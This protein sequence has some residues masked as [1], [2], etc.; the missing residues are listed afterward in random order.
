VESNRPSALDSLAK[1]LK[2]AVRFRPKRY[3]VAA[4]ANAAARLLANLEP[5]WISFL[6]PSV[7]VSVSGERIGRQVKSLASRIADRDELPSLLGRFPPVVADG[8]SEFGGVDEQLAA[9]L[10]RRIVDGSAT[11]RRNLEDLLTGSPPEWLVTADPLAWIALAEAASAYSLL[12]LS[13]QA[14]ERAVT[15]GA[16]NPSRWLGR[17]SLAWAQTGDR[18][19]ARRVCDAAL[20]GSARDQFAVV[21]D[22]ILREDPAAVLQAVEASNPGHAEHVAL[23]GQAAIALHNLG[24]PDA[25]IERLRA[26]LSGKP[27]LT[28]LAILLAR[29]LVGR[30]TRT[31]GEDRERDL[32]EALKLATEA[33]DRRRAWGMA[34]E[35]AIPILCDIAV[36][37]GDRAAVL[38]YGLAE[39]DGEATAAEAAAT[40]VAEQTALRFIERG[41]MG[42]ARALFS[43]LP[44]GY[45]RL[46][47]EGAL[48]RDDATN[49]DRAV[50]VL[51]QA[52]EAA[53]DPQ[54]RWSAVKLLA[55]LGEWPL[56]GW[57]ELLEI[58]PE[59]AEFF[60]A[61]SMLR[62]GLFDDAVRLLRP[63]SADSLIHAELLA[64]A[65]AKNGHVDA[66]VGTYRA[67]AVRFHDPDL[68]AE[69]CL[70]LAEAGR[71]DEAEE[72]TKSAMTRL[73]PDSVNWLPLRR[74]LIDGA[75]RRHEWTL[76][77]DHATRVLSRDPAQRGIRWLL[78][79]AH[80]NSLAFAEAWKALTEGSL[81]PN[82]AEH[83]ELW[84]ELAHRN[85]RPADWIETA[86][87]LY[88]RFPDSE[89]MAETFVKATVGVE[90]GALAPEVGEQVRAAVAAFLSR[91]PTNKVFRQID[92][93]NGNE[94]AIVEKFKEMF[95]QSATHHADLAREVIRG[96]KPL[97]L[98]ASLDGK[99]YTEALAT[100]GTGFLNVVS[101]DRA[102]QRADMEAA[103]SGLNSRI[104]VDVSA[105]FTAS[106]IPDA[107]RLVEAE[108]ERIVLGD[109]AFRDVVAGCDALGRLSTVGLSYDPARDRL[110]MNEL[111]QEEAE[112]RRDRTAW[113]VTA[114][115]R[116]DRVQLQS[117]EHFPQADLGRFGGWLAGLELAAQMKLPFLCD[118]AA[119]REIARSIGVA[120]FSSVHFLIVLADVGRLKREA[121]DDYIATLRSAR[122]VDLP[123][124]TA[125]IVELAE[126]EGWRPGIASLQL[127]R[128]GFWVTP[129]A[130]EVYDTICAKV[131]ST[132]PD[133]LGG[134]VAAAA[135]GQS[136]RLPV[137][138]A[139]PTAA[140]VLSDAIL[141]Y[142][143]SSLDVPPLV[144]AVREAAANLGLPDPLPTAAKN[145]R[146]RL[147]E[148]LGPG[149]AA[150]VILGLTQNLAESDRRTVSEALFTTA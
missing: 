51:N 38:R 23:E 117:L 44:P 108:T 94:E 26:V 20:L 16:S 93:G 92:F 17:A 80:Y 122:I 102:S 148:K 129:A 60:E 32:Q 147:G 10:V 55:D 95:R 77:I 142:G 35:E 54:E 68:D 73:R 121:L 127:T 90:D 21:A 1:A 2:P 124:E 76:V 105:L 33:R 14:F 65:Y 88:W 111:S 143:R 79:A 91:Y 53:T 119:Q 58:A 22:T 72:A 56:P 104:V 62:R 96:A 103:R 109:L 45:S 82:V 128:P 43:Q 126:S 11:V 98:L 110:S 27:E 136:L 132:A 123:F 7:A 144:E 106:V 149:G 118:D 114:A 71:L 131:N 18:A 64:Q 57:E 125:T 97:G 84:I 135:Y 113:M 139:T 59:Q 63:K 28:G 19:A 107:W 12:A 69:A 101:A 30:A 83:A 24:R 150:P 81:E 37:H 112:R 75:W 15:A 41:Q 36:I 140:A 116:L 47:V 3:T 46:L 52:F 31:T 50:L 25:A 6:E 66:S 130:L 85:V 4:R 133:L 8:F 134:W 138:L 87:A 49:R 115:G 137:E 86:L 146:D 74:I 29:F 9:R 48:L 78:V 42:R 89:R 141:R 100:G 5:D 99:P 70:V 13:A 34:S 67:A 40:H 120:T 61:L 39:P 145:L